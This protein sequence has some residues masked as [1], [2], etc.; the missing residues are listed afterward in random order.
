MS[1][2]YLV[3]YKD[4]TWRAEMG[5]YDFSNTP[6][7]VSWPASQNDRLSSF[8]FKL[9]VG[10]ELRIHEHGNP[11][12]R[13]KAW[14]GTGNEVRVNKN[15]LP[16]F[17]HDEAS[18]HSWIR[19]HFSS[20]LQAFNAVQPEGPTHLF[21]TKPPVIVMP[22]GYSGDSTWH[23]QGIQK[24]ARG[25]FIVSGS[26][27]ETGYLYFTDVAR[28]IVKVVIPRISTEPPSP[29]VCNHLGGFQ[30]AGDFLAVGYERFQS[31]SSGTSKILLYDIANIFSP[32]ALDHLTI[33]RARSGDT[34]GA[35]ALIFLGDCWLVLV[36]NWD[37]ARLDFYTSNSADLRHS[38]TRFSTLPRWSWAKG[39]NGF[40]SGSVDN[41]WGGYQN[42]NLFTQA[43]S[44]PR[45]EDLW[46]VGM[47]E[48]W[49]DLYQ[50]S[51][52]AGAPLVTKRGK[53]QFGGGHGFTS[54]SG[55]F[56][57]TNVRA[58]EV[59]SAETHFGNGTTSRVDR[60]L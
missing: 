49:A 29:Q 51:L 52:G 33:T 38:A 60:W 10:W 26:S 55:F 1:T 50:L 12:S 53:K 58:F 20:I 44:P 3:T 47:H 25:E 24:T 11:A 17:I 46:F 23:Q 32:V 37:A 13:F 16:G 41:N 36:A 42:I 40:G 15:E 48:N 8:K 19:L 39:I 21:V 56:Y 31:K 35:V 34:A 45:L 54:A 28:T 9:P 59:Y 2:N 14:L 7:F 43:G 4:D 6:A 22:A 18:G 57:D 30:V 5:R 27:P